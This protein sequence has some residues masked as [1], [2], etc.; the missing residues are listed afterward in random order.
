MRFVL[1][2][3][4]VTV[5]LIGACAFPVD[6]AERT[7][8][9]DYLLEANAEL[10]QCRSEAAIASR[11]PSDHSNQV[12]GTALRSCG[13]GSAAR[14]NSYYQSALTS[15]RWERGTTMY[16][17]LHYEQWQIV[18]NETIRRLVG[19]SRQEVSVL[20]A[21]LDRLGQIEGELR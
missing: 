11:S 20:E 7:A 14:V 2:F 3:I 5:P 15:V 1:L 9:R 17:K 8:V 10:Q 4:G 16:L 6:R 19:R 12:G 13:P 18:M 21:E